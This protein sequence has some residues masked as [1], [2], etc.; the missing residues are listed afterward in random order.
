MKKTFWL[1]LRVLLVLVAV[2]CLVDWAVLRVRV[3]RG[4][5]YGTVQVDDYLST[6][7]KGT[8]DEFDYLGSEAVPCVESLF[9]HGMQTCW[10]LRRHSSHWQR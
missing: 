9:P 1:G 3:S 7:L 4:T 2:T 5:A 6:P 8:K 10:W